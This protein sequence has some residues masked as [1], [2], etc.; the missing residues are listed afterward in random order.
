LNLG[1]VSDE[2]WISTPNNIFKTA[3]IYSTVNMMS[4]PAL[5]STNT[6]PG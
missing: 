6:I 3:M 1:K 5:S 4:Q 2:L